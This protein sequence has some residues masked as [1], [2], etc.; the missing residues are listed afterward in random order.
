MD[1]REL[2]NDILGTS[3]PPVVAAATHDRQEAEAAR[4]DATVVP[5]KLSD[6]VISD[7]DLLAGM[8]ERLARVKAAAAEFDGI[9]NHSVSLDLNDYGPYV[10]P[11]WWVSCLRKNGRPIGQHGSTFDSA[12][13]A[14]VAEARAIP[15]ICPT[16]GA[17]T[18]KH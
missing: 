16:C 1:A 7:E 14:V 6:L 18:C 15:V 2:A 13:A 10:S 4:E 11:R 9:Q 3:L 12:L 17:R 8:A 5:P